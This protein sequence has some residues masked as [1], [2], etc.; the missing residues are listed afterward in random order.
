MSNP[1]PADG[2]GLELLARSYALRERAEQGLY[3]RSH[4]AQ[5]VLCEGLQLGGDH[6]DHLRKCVVGLDGQ[7]ARSYA[8]SPR[9]DRHPGCAR[10]TRILSS[11]RAFSNRCATIASR[12]AARRLGLDPIRNFMDYTDACPYEFTAG[13]DARMDAMRTTYR[14]GK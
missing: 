12:S 1:R 5:L 9:L 11:T 3:D 2:Q 13:Q 10:N 6:R 8:N 14:L 7:L 4:V